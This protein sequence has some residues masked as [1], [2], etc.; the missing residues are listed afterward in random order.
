MKKILLVKPD[1]RHFPLGIAYVCRELAVNDIPFDFIDTAIDDIRSIELLIKNNDYLA[2]ATGGLSADWLFFQDLRIMVKQFENDLPFILGGSVVK[3]TMYTNPDILFEDDKFGIDFGVHG[4]AEGVLLPLLHA[5]ENGSTDYSKIPGIIYIDSDTGKPKKNPKYRFNLEDNNR[6]PMWEVIDVEFYKHNT[7]PFLGNVNMM[8]IVSGR[9]CQGVCSFCSPTVGRFKKRPL[10]HIMNEIEWIEANYEFDMLW[11][12]NEMFYDTKADVVAFCN[13]YKKHF[14]KPWGCAF[15]AEIDVDASVFRTMKDAGCVFVSAGV[16]S[17]SDHVLNLMKK[18]TPADEIRRFF[19]EAKKAEMPCAGTFIVGNEGETEKDLAETIDMV[20]EDDIYTD[21]A[22][23]DAYPGTLAYKHALQK[24]LINDE[25]H[26]LTNVSF[27]YSVWGKNYINEYV[28]IS[29]IP[30]DVFWPTIYR[31]LRRFETHSYHKYKLNNLEWKKSK[32]LLRQDV[33]E[34]EGICVQCGS[35]I[36]KRVKFQPI[37]Q[38]VHC[39]HCYIVNYVHYYDSPRMHV[40]YSG[41]KKQL[42]LS[43]KLLF[44]GGDKGVIRYDLFDINYNNSV[45]G[46]F[47]CNDHETLDYYSKNVAERVYD[48]KIIFDINPDTILVVDDKIGRAEL[49]IKML[50]GKYNVHIPNVIHLLPD[51]MR[52]G[53]KLVRLVESFNNPHLNYIIYSIVCM[54]L[55]A[56]HSLFSQINPDVDSYTRRLLI[57]VMPRHLLLKAREFFNLVIRR[58]FVRSSK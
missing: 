17:G 7:M 31:E 45:V 25:W 47:E 33:S 29:D 30:D 26:H 3:D 52:R 41:L 35:P 32:S 40:H 51:D 44:I 28:N 10:K 5:I 16:E 55:E 18:M 4:E 6:F 19:R 56:T 50:Y 20:I 48:I 58:D 53:I 13:E 14:S 43:N 57:T 9:G 34:I 1:Y 49:D 23:M 8:P 42:A 15:R 11:F 2:V 24:G 46:F 21:S 38:I 39:D 22:L 36:S 27:N 54:Y 37:G 12:L